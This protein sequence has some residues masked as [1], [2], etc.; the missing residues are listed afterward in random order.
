MFGAA[1]PTLSQTAGCSVEEA[2]EVVDKLDK[3][4]A[5]MTAF[6]KR[7]SKFVRDNG[8]IIMC[9]H[10][11]HRMYWWDHKDWLERQ[12]SF[13]SEFWDDYRLHHKGT[14]DSV[15][16]M[17]REHL[18]PRVSNIALYKSRKFGEPCD[19]NTEPSLIGI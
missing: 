5:G 6:A 1:A 18:L 9:K 13:T 16:M 3:A 10:T 11:G 17:V 12:K 4:F 19:G 8:Y 7:G 2:Q 14:G 15:A